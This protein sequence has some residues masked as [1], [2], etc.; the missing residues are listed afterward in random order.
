MFIYISEMMY[1]SVGNNKETIICNNTLSVF[2]IKIY[3]FKK[4][5]ITFNITVP[6]L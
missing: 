6:F 5:K 1:Y 2:F 4:K 3:S